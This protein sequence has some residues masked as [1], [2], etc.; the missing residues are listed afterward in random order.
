MNAKMLKQLQQMQKDMV[1]TQKEIE[2]AVF[3]GAAGGIV[4]VQMNGKKEIM[5]IEILENPDD[6]ELLADLIKMATNQAMKEVDKT[7]EQKMS[8]F[9]G[10]MQGLGF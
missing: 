9:A 6:M 2:E 3:K 4:S 1:R 7:T 8:K 5:E 10:G